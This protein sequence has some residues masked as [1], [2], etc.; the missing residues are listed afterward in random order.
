MRKYL[1]KGLLYEWFNASKVPIVI[2][3]ITWGVIAHMDLKSDMRYMCQMIGTAD[4][5]NYEASNLEVYLILVFIF[6]A[7]Y[8]F[9]NGANKRNTMMF[10]CSGPYTKKQIKVNE[11]IC[12]LMTL[13]L[14]VIMYIYM[15]VTMYVQNHEFISIVNGYPQVIVIEIFRLLLFG[16]IG[17]F[18]LIEIDLLFSNSII[19]YFGMIALL[20]ST[21]FI[22][23]KLRIIMN[24]LHILTPKIDAIFRYPGHR[25]YDHANILF[26]GRPYY[27]GEW[28]KTFKTIAVLIIIIAIMLVIFNIFEKKYKLEASSKIFSCKANENMIVTYISLAIGSFADLLIVDGAFSN[29]LFRSARIQPYVSVESFEMLA[30]DLIIIGVVTF[31]SYRIIKKIL[32]AIG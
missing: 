28:A 11:L 31:I 7:I 22:S 4:S 29:R 13:G 12:L 21:M 18:L 6:L 23:I 30:T 24:Y 16:T 8:I 19:A 5:N 20:V 1:N 15:A 27:S 17:I 25:D 9:A 26:Y 14:F 2:G 32:K 10:L 3:L